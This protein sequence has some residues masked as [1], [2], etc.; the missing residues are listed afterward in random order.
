MWIHGDCCEGFS[1][2]GK[3]HPRQ[4]GCSFVHFSLVS[5]L[6]YPVTLEHRTLYFY[7]DQQLLLELL[8]PASLGQSRNPAID[9]L[10]QGQKMHLRCSLRSHFHQVPSH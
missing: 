7:I 2:F 5:S 3:D 6:Q 8:R 10:T 9:L 4:K 1:G